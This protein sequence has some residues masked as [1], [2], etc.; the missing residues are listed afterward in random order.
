MGSKREII[1][2]VKESVYSLEVNGGW[3]CDLFAGT[4]I[5]SGSLKEDF[6]IHANDIQ[7]YSSVLSYTYLLNLKGVGAKVTI[8]DILEKTSFLV[9]EFENKYTMLKFDYS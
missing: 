2:F 6:N 7:Q 3:L 1:N 9:S 4:G 5:V 8:D